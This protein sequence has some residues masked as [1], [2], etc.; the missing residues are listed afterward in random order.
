[1]SPPPRLASHTSAREYHIAQVST[2]STV[3][4]AWEGDCHAA[5]SRLSRDSQKRWGSTSRLRTGGING[6]EGGG[7]RGRT[8]SHP[9]TREVRASHLPGS[10]RSLGGVEPRALTPPPGKKPPRPRGCSRSR[11]CVLACSWR[12]EG[13]L[14]RGCHIR[15]RAWRCSCCFGRRRRSWPRSSCLPCTGERRLARDRGPATNRYAP[16]TWCQGLL[17]M[18]MLATNAGRGEGG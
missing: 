14:G 7:G 5:H 12:T 1:M 15:R 11:R 4:E 16:G 18:G 2:S 9:R 8:A 17:P 3:S 13:N 6:G 10:R